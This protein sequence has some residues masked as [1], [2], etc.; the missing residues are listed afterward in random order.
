MAVINVS[1]KKELF[2]FLACAMASEDSSERDGNIR[3]EQTKTDYWINR[4]QEGQTGWH[5]VDINPYVNTCCTVIMYA[6]MIYHWFIL[7][8]F[9]F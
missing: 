8:K 2:K 5:N 7:L 4:W 6:C 1:D 3:D 9:V